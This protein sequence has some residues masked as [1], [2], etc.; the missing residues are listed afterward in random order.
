M[1]ARAEKVIETFRTR[2]I[3][4]DFTLDHDAAERV[5]R[6]FRRIAEGYPDDDDEWGAV[7]DFFGVHGSSLDWVLSGRVEGMICSSAALTTAERR[8]KQAADDA[9]LLEMEN[10]IF[11]LREK[12]EAFDPEIVWVQEVWAAEMIHL[13]DAA[14]VGECKLSK[15]ERS[16]AVAAMPEAIEHARLV[17]LQRPLQERADELVARMWSTPART[18]EGRRA[19]LLVLLGYV[20]ADSWREDDGEV[21]YD[22]RM[23]RDLMIEFIGGEPAPQLRDQFA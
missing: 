21:D 6:Y 8:R 14:M 12:I 9:A 17:T 5:L 20:M 2:F 1:L 16:A 3:S 13:H 18:P 19:K 11:E 15:K 23:A 7:I 4:E 10:K 22:I